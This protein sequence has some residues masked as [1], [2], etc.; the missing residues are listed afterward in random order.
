[1]GSFDGSRVGVGDG[2]SEGSS[3]GIG[4]GSMVTDGDDV[5]DGVGAIPA[6]QRNGLSAGKSSPM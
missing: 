3:D 6:Y 5:G 2:S 4:V 1:V